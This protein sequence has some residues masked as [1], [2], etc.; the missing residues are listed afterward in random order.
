MGILGLQSR[1]NVNYQ[2]YEAIEKIMY[3]FNNEENLLYDK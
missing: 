2:T 3:S 1:E